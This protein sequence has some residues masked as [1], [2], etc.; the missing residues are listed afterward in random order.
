MDQ[1]RSIWAVAIYLVAKHGVAAPV[2][3]RRHAA[4]GDHNRAPEDI[5]WLR[6]A[7]AAHDLL[8]SEAVKEKRLH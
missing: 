5:E 3:A 2:V 4:I 6:V 1:K 8:Q 7:E